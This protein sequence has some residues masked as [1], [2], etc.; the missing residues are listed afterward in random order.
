MNKATIIQMLEDE[1]QKLLAVLEGIPHE[2]MLTSGVQGPWSIK[3]ILNHLN[4][5]EAE[6][7]TQLWFAQQGQKPGEAS[8]SAEKID[9]LNQQWYREG[10]DRPLDLVIADF[11]AVRKQTI[12]RV[13]SFS[14]ED[15]T[16]P[17]RYPW[18]RGISMAER[19]ASYSYEHEAEHTKQIQKWKLLER[20]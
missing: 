1:R 15:F 19:I 7:V 11:H 9:Q 10:R 12:R 20:L 4:H 2:A 5:W 18:L 8:H 16:R 13:D 6:L 14:D 3:D 17:G